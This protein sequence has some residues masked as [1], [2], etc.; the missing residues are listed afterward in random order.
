MLL[1]VVSSETPKQLYR[2][3]GAPPHKKTPLLPRKHALKGAL[4]PILGYLALYKGGAG[5]A[6]GKPSFWGIFGSVQREN[7]PKVTF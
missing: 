2:V 6:G 3:G 7:P 1:Y 5:S 4:M